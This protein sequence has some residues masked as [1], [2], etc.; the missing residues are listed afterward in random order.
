MLSPD[1]CEVFIEMFFTT[2]HEFTDPLEVLLCIRMS[3]E[4]E[5]SKTL[6]LKWLK[7]FPHDFVEMGSKLAKWCPG[8]ASNVEHQAL[9]PEQA[10]DML[11]ENANFVSNANDLADVM[12]IMLKEMSDKISDPAA[13][14]DPL[15]YV[16]EMW[17]AQESRPGSTRIAPRGKRSSSKMIM[18]TLDEM[19]LPA[20]SRSQSFSIHDYP[21]PSYSPAE[22]S[23]LPPAGPSYVMPDPD[24]EGP[25]FSGQ[26]ATEANDNQ[27]DDGGASDTSSM[28]MPLP[29]PMSEVMIAERPPHYDYMDPMSALAYVIYEPSQVFQDPVSSFK[30]DEQRKPKKRIGSLFSIVLKEPNGDSEL[31]ELIV[32]VLN[33]ISPLVIASS[34]QPP[35]HRMLTH[36]S[37]PY[38]YPPPVP[39]YPFDDD[40][41]I[42]RNCDVIVLPDPNADVETVAEDMALE[43]V[44]P[45]E[46]A[47]QLYLVV[48]QVFQ[49]IEPREF[50]GCLW[51]KKDKQYK[52]SPHIMKAIEL[53]NNIAKYFATYIILSEQC[54]GE[55]VELLGAARI[56]RTIQIASSVW[57]T[58]N[59]F[60][61]TAVIS[62]LQSMAVQGLH[63]YWDHVPAP[64][65]AKLNELTV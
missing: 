37:S 14:Q 1:A 38:T 52:V 22:R 31:S 40:L 32:A 24:L 65:T 20:P 25:M 39:L 54:V 2:L 5:A 43:C 64:A 29:S 41:S 50:V 44:D 12:K 30:T 6:L 46:I 27:I 34:S 3:H 42:D 47:R 13:A 16:L 36:I 58:G 15:Q 55:K 11:L 33:D 48:Q 63:S 59:F 45:I 51:T 49:S 53:F 26:Y 8:Y 62:A 18:E 21:S 60:A 28:D 4:K 57:A 10:V 17:Y 61:L 9:T 56:L 23:S 19:S 35:G 7:L